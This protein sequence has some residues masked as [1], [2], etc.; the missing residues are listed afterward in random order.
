MSGNSH[1][2]QTF[3]KALEGLL[4]KRMV[5]AKPSRDIWARIYFWVGLFVAFSALGLPLIG[6][7]INLWLG[8][9]LLA[10]A[11]IAI[12]RAF[13]IW[14]SPWRLHVLLR[15]ATVMIAGTVYF[16]LV[17]NQMWHEYRKEYP[18]ET[19]KKDPPLQ[20]EPNETPHTTDKVEAKPE[21]H[22]TTDAV[23]PK[24]VRNDR[25]RHLTPLQKEKLRAIAVDFQKEDI[26]VVYYWSSKSTE[27][28]HYVNEFYE[29]FP[30]A[31]YMWGNSVVQPP[32]GITVTYRIGDDKAMN[33]ANWLSV[34]LHDAGIAASIS[35]KYF[36]PGQSIPNSVSIVVGPKPSYD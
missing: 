35:D 27:S 14:E 18:I 30:G 21:H 24:V 32:E 2:R 9:A 31:R 26:H 13:W 6:V 3:R 36:G 22:G 25:E 28:E 10:G 12:V 29:V 11:F 15:L 4:E 1:Q 20:P 23:K 16:F 34:R 19:A 8:G 7:A 17:G 33:A 5:N